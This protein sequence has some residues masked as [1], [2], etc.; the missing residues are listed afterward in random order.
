M[1]S[2][3]GIELPYGDHNG[4]GTLITDSDY[5]SRGHTAIMVT[6]DQFA[7]NE[8]MQVSSFNV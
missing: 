2:A 3:N 7:Q 8:A 4:H 5:L 6:D 1:M